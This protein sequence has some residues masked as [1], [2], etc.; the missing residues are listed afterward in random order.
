MRMNINCKRWYARA[1]WAWLLLPVLAWMVLAGGP[2]RGEDRDT[3]AGEENEHSVDSEH[4][5]YVLP[6]EGV[7]DQGLMI[8]F[9][10]AF[11]E[12]EEAEPDLL[13][14]EI[15][16]PGG[17]LLETEEIIAWMRAAKV[18]IYA[19]VNRHAQSAGAIVSF[20]S[21]R[22]F[23]APG[24]RIGSALPVIMAPGGAAD[25][26]EKVHEKMISDT[27]AMVRGIAREKGHWEDIAV[28]MVDPDYE[29]KVNDH[30]ISEAG[31]LLNLTAREAVEV[32]PPREKPVLAEAIVEDLEA[33]LEH[34][35]MEDAEVVEFKSLP[36]ESLARWIIMIGP[37]LFALGIL[38]IYMEFRTPGI[39]LPGMV[40][41]VCLLIYF[42]GHHVGG[43]AGI[44]DLALLVLGLVLIAVEVFVI[45]GFGVAG[46]LG[47]ISLFTGLVMSLV[48]RLPSLP[49]EFP[50][51]A[52]PTLI[53]YLPMISLR[54]MAIVLLTGIGAWLMS[55]LVPKTQFY[56]KLVLQKT[57]TSDTGYTSAD[58]GY[59]DYL[60]REGV[61]LTGLRPSGTAVFGD[62]RLDV[63]S[64]GDLIERG[65][66]IKVIQVEGN[67]I[68]VEKVK[69]SQ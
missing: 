69:E 33:L 66:E 32:I 1:A 67:R 60:G 6:L 65:A 59:R 62:D 29:V 7:I 16:T 27:R 50:D 25:L 21:D 45:P 52:S 2:V 30:V 31:K 40:G 24:S 10:R 36:A 58:T 23:M 55:W 11:K 15:D 56:G 9:R 8:L 26:P 3:A 61:A 19:F 20:G 17:R 28:A 42:F 38:G 4:L 14:I 63:V 12:I 44:E 48:P 54:L 57:L 41:A 13:I 35:G 39:G 68:V 46:I 49:E 51:I 47:L 43:L 37:A 34:V 64:S 22:I 5:V 18:P 53:D